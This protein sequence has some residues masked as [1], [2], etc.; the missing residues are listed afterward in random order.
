MGSVVVW[1]GNLLQLRVI[2]E[3]CVLLVE[4]SVSITLNFKQAEAVSIS[5]SAESS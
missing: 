3:V 4:F 2:V 1:S 5:N